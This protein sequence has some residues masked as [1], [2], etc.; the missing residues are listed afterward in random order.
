MPTDSKIKSYLNKCVENGALSHAYVFYGPNKNLRTDTSIWFANQILK[1]ESLKFHPDLF[2]IQTEA[3]SEET[4]ISLVGQIKSFLTLKPYSSRYKVVIV[5]SAEKLHSSAQNALLKI[6]E[7]APRYAVIILS[8]NMLS[9][10]PD[11]IAS[12]AIKVPF[13]YQQ[14]EIFSRDKT[15]DSIITD[16]FTK[17]S[18]NKYKHMEKLSSLNPSVFFKYWL[19]FLRVEFKNN[20]NEQLRILLSKSQNIYFKLAETNSNPKFAYDELL[21]AL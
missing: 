9:S 19:N 18:A 10:I 6:F 5:E 11:T 8:I 16:I 12:R 4:D 1:N 3:I 7:E 13:W 20:P 2:I 17:D 14:P 21:L 15:F